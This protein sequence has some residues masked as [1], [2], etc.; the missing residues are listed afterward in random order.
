MTWYYIPILTKRGPK[1]LIA[2]AYVVIDNEK[3]C[4][5]EFIKKLAGPNV[6][7]YNTVLY[8]RQL[9]ITHDL[10][11]KINEDEKIIKPDEILNIE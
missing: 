3:K 10:Y 1:P 5:T 4:Y 8:P 2:E 7:F 6:D 11:I 9:G